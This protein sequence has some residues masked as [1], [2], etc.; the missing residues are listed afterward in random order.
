MSQLIN[1]AFQHLERLRYR[2]KEF[3]VDGV[4]ITGVLVHGNSHGPLVYAAVHITVYDKIHVTVIS[5]GQNPDIMLVITVPDLIFI[6]AAEGK[7]LDCLFGRLVIRPQI[8]IDHIRNVAAIRACFR[9]YLVII[10]NPEHNALSGKQ[11]AL[12]G[13]DLVGTALKI[14]QINALAVPF[15]GEIVFHLVEF[16][17]AVVRSSRYLIIQADI[18]HD[19]VQILQRYTDITHRLYI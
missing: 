6:A 7:D 8:S 17:H 5:D 11:I 12:S 9:S 16:I 3:L 15:H 10:H 19:S 2:C 14:H 13:K 1:I 18:T 4:L